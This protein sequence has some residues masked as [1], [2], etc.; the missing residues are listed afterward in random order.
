MFLLWRSVRVWLKETVLKTVN[1][2]PFG[3]SNPSSSALLFFAIVCVGEYSSLGMVLA[4][5]TVVLVVDALGYHT[6]HNPCITFNDGV[7]A[8]ESVSADDSVP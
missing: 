8:D 7:P 1:G 3:G 4:T 5:S 2:Q 6:R